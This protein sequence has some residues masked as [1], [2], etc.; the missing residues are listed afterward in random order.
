M[1]AFEIDDDEIQDQ[2]DAYAAEFNQKL[3]EAYK[4]LEEGIKMVKDAEEQLR[5]LIGVDQ[6]ILKQ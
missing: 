6:S 2:V 1:N 5:Y 3:S 4:Q